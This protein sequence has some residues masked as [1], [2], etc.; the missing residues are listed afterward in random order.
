MPM[1]DAEILKAVCCLAGADSEVTVEELQ[2]LGGLA[3]NAGLE[4]HSVDAVIEKAHNDQ[5]FHQRQLDLVMRDVDGAMNTLIRV[6]REGGSLEGHVV[7]LLWRV[8]TK[9][10]MSPER[11]E[12]LLAAADRDS[13]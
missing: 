9:L 6:A 11:F 4:R 1:T 2:F 3:R 8:A 5:D 7:L 13:P 12:D 10:Q